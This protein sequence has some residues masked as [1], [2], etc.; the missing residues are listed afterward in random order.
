VGWFYAIEYHADGERAH[1]HA[2]IANTE[3]LTIAS[4]E[5]PWILGDCRAAIYDPRRGA[6]HYVCKH[7]RRNPEPYDL[8]RR[9]LPR[10]GNL[11]AQEAA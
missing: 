11:D 8:S 3:T 1:V 4:L 2:L 10:G 9:H 7:L 6:S 5:R